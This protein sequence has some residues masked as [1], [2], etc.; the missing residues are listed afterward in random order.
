MLII[1][2][3]TKALS[4]HDRYGVGAMANYRIILEP[5][6]RA[7]VV[8]VND[9]KMNGQAIPILSIKGCAN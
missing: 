2:S 5:M 6:L 7:G 4:C 3:L 1:F 9:F 8:R